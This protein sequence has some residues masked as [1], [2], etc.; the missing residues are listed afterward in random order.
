MVMAYKL[1]HWCGEPP[2]SF[3]NVKRWVVA[4]AARIVTRLYRV[5]SEK[6]QHRG[7]PQQWIAD[8][9]GIYTPGA[10]ATMFFNV[11]MFFN[12]ICL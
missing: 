8:R 5:L 7:P 2:R 9:K 11:V 6:M 10:V 1:K 3:A 12:V 4:M